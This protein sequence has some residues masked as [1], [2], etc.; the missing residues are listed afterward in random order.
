MKIITSRFIASIS[1]ALVLSLPSAFAAASELDVAGIWM[2]AGNGGIVE[3]K[4]CGDG[5]PCGTLIW[6]TPFK[7]G[8]LPKDKNNPDKDLA[9]R[10]MIGISMLLDF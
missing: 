2:T 8:T 1:L 10:D 5:T 4:D 3:I 6:V 7:D 9:Q